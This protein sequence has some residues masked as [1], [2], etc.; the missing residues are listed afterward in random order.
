VVFF[1]IIQSYV[2]FSPGNVYIADTGNCVIR[3]VASS[4]NK[5]F[6]IAGTAGYCSYSGDGNSATSANLI[7]PPAVCVDSKGIYYTN[8]FIF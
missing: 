2:V 1:I 7:Y 6:T 3:K 5:I 4:T 8:T